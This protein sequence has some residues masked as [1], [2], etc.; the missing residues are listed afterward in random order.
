MSLSLSQDVTRYIGSHHC[1]IWT[2]AHSLCRSILW[3]LGWGFVQ[4]CVMG[5][6]RQRR[7]TG[8][9]MD[10]K[11]QDS[12]VKMSHVTELWHKI[13][14]WKSPVCCL[15]GQTEIG[16]KRIERYIRDLI[17]V[18]YIKG[19]TDWCSKECLNHWI[20]T[21]LCLKGKSCDIFLAGNCFQEKLRTINTFSCL[22]RQS[23]S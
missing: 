15:A 9:L 22:Y 8:E 17:K 20:N 18:L 21:S 6:E 2:A 10:H 4:K 19:P 13:V 11:T 3:K 1:P 23:N 12:H 5:I 14:Q 16:S 7:K